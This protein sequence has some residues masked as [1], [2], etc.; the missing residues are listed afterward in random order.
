MRDIANIVRGVRELR[1]DLTKKLTVTGGDLGEVVE[2]IN[3]MASDIL[4]AEEEHKALLMAEAA[5]QAQR[6]FLARMSH[7]I[8][9]PM[10]GVIGMTLLA[11]S[12]PTEEQRMEYID[13]IQLSASL[14]LGIINDILDFSKIEAG[15]MQ[16][17]NTPFCI[18]RVVDTVRDIIQPKADEKNLVLN[19]NMDASTPEMVRGD[20]MRL[21]QIL[22]NL[23]GNAIKFTQEGSV[24]LTMKAGTS[25]GGK[26]RLFC[27]VR[28]TGIGMNE[29]Q[30][31]NILKPFAQADIST[32]RKFGGTG[33]G[34]SISKALTELM[35]GDLTIES[36]PGK[37][38]EFSFTV[39]LEPYDGE[40]AQEQ[41]ATDEVQAQ[42]YDGYELLIVEDNEINRIIAET[43]LSEMGFTID[44][45]EDGKEG[46]GAFR[47]KRYDM[48]FMDIRM[49]V[50]DGFEA[51]R[52]IRKIEAEREAAG[53]AV[54][55]VPIVAMTANAMQE[56]RELSR[57]AGM[58][59]HV[60]KPINIIE[61][62]SVLYDILIRP[63]E[64]K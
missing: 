59:G 40:T 41:L 45:A 50:M 27:S 9:T 23:L 49:P 57:G 61:V 14:L 39:V 38:S 44:M 25:E 42:R 33:L 43:L 63:G 8:R 53:A 12:A 3:A 20:G 2:S 32:A 4:K 22:L 60:S 10:N 28:D 47:K 6:D 16:I 62:K 7:E 56:D 36:A 55:R 31:N 30:M 35:G 46:V 54:P 29:E 1:H 15:K 48:I 64:E 51:T 58:D 19:I 11:K 52:E 24:T 17:E 18:S 34:L 5:N 21:S 37:G 26:L 13:K